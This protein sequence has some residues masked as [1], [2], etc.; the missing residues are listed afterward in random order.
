MKYTKYLLLGLCLQV[1]RCM[2]SE[3]IA[4][5]VHSKLLPA[6]RTA[7]DADGVD[8]VVIEPRYKDRPNGTKRYIFH[9]KDRQG[10]PKT[11]IQLNE[12]VQ[13]ISDKMVPIK[14]VG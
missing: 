7:Y 11:L 13:C 2:R 9:V 14:P 4:E 3:D 10:N 5:F 1:S 12:L 6:V 8:S